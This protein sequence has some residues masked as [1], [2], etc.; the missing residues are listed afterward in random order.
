MSVV[1]VTTAELRDLIRAAVRDEL[2]QRGAESSRPEWCT[3]EEACRELKCSR[4]KLIRERDKG[5]PCAYI[6]GSPRYRIADCIAYFQQ[7]SAARGESE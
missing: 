4:A 5:M 1:V 7:R 3:T 2:D 6:G